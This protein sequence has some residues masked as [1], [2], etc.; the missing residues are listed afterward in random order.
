MPAVVL[1]LMFIATVVSAEEPLKQHD[2]GEALELAKKTLGFVLKSAPRPKLAAELKDLEKKIGAAGGEADELETLAGEVRSL[3]RRIILSHP[4]LDFDRL[5]INKRPPPK[6]LYAHQCDQYYGRHSKAGP[7]L[8]VLDSW[9]DDPRETVI[10]EGKLPAGSVLHPDL[11]FDGKRVIFAFC[12]HTVKKDDDVY[13]PTHPRVARQGCDN[14]KIG[15]RRFFIYEATID[16]SE[17]RQLTGTPSDPMQTTDN[18]K[19]VLVED[20]DPCYLPDG[21]FVFTSTRSQNFGR[22]HW[23][24]YTPSFLLYR[25]NADGSGIR[26]I[27]FAEANEWDPAV[28][29]DGRIVYTRWDYINRNSIW[30][31][32]LWVTNPDGTSTA[33][34]YGNYSKN[35]NVIAETIPIPGSHKVVATASAHHFISGGSIIL[36]DPSKG[37]DG[38]DPL[39]RVTPE[40]K[41]PETEGWG[42][43]GCY[44]TPYPL[45]E[46]LFLAAYS[47][48][49]VNWERAN[50][51]YSGTWP[52]EAAFGIYLVDTLGGRELIYRDPDVS[53]FAP[54][55]VRVRPKPQAVPS[56]LADSAAGTVTGTCY[57]QDVYK[58]RHPISQGSIKYLRI[59]RIFNQ[60]T[61]SFT[62]RSRAGEEIV[63]NVVGTV[64]VNED[65]SVA[66]RAPA[67]VGLQL[68]ILDENKMAVMTMRSLI[69]L[70][71]GETI[72]CVG[73][74]EPRGSTP[75]AKRAPKNLTVHD[76][77]PVSGTGYEGGFSFK[78]TI[79]PVL[80]RY[81]IKCHGLNEKKVP[82]GLVLFGD[83]SYRLLTGRKG[84]VKIAMSNAETFFS[85][86]RD[87]FA[88][89]GKLATMLI[90]GHDKLKLPEKD[91]E[92]IITW[93]DL[94]GQQYGDYSFNRIEQRGSSPEGEK[95]LRR[96]V[97]EHFGRE[98][99]EQPFAALVNVGQPDES[100]ILKLRLP[101]KAGGWLGEKVEGTV[102]TDTKDPRYGKLF[103]LVEASIAPLKYHDIDGTCGQDKCVCGC[104]WVRKLTAGKQE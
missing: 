88:H 12:D 17:V 81:C 84:M 58:G 90:K 41:F 44:S 25:A 36:V 92:R 20:M 15:R 1:L 31:Q 65:G 97:A 26:Q 16:G 52:T 43:K 47:P 28:L 93:L 69:Y 5:L 83:K 27:S 45:T 29:H 63:K 64:P 78:R 21:G 80:D 54:I 70:Q 46:D 68:Q 51:Q 103:E 95:V 23:G 48:E 62:R 19:T 50:S 89:A 34:F 3:R 6:S 71:P 2:A 53:C 60:P 72:S 7:G 42:L 10:L 9:K 75:Y 102:F 99:S 4:V 24:R 87:Y 82:E 67:G 18:R 56:L 11:S 35:P 77:K 96:Y 38:M 57:V 73:C 8:V 49:Q 30:F 55:P 98:L 79:Q 13:I 61:A 66:F 14:D 91:L 22:C 32:S 59:N 37:E 104:C 100:R 94:N 76:P 40:V 85:K 39:T 74:H 33:H 101:E 86:P